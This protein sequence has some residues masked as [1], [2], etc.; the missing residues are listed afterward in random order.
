VNK[1]IILISAL[2][3]IALI[4]AWSLISPLFLNKIVNESLPITQQENIKNSEENAQPPAP[5]ETER[6]G[7]FTDADAFHKTSGE[8]RILTI[9]E[10]RYLS[11]ENF[12][13]TNG[14]DLYVY[15]STDKEST[16]FINLGKLKGNIGNQNY[17]IPENA[18]VTKYNRVVIWCR[19][20]SV[21]FGSAELK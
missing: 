13:T 2:S 3:L 20:F 21:L 4:I 12:K 18:D 19:A 11:L 16:E 1:K 15:L 14:P 7:I 9:N 10:K 8:A 5:I 17:E 6:R